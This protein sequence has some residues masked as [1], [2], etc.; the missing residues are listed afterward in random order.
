MSCSTC[1]SRAIL[2][3]SEQTERDISCGKLDAYDWLKDIPDS[4]EGTKLVEVRFKNTRKEF[5]YNEKDLDLK[6]GEYVAVEAERGHDIGQITLTGTV[7]KMQLK[8]KNPK[9]LNK[10]IVYRKATSADL[11]KWQ[12]ARL[13]ERS[14]LIKARQ[15]AEN[16]QLEMKVSDVEFQGDGTKATFYYIAE[17]RIDFRELIKHFAQSF[18]VKIDMRQI[19]SRQEAALIG[20]IGSCGKELCCSTW[21][22]N[23]NTVLT[24]AA[25]I[26]D[27]PHN[28]QKLTGQCGKLKCCLM[29]E[30]GTYLEAQ[31]DF[32][33]VLLELEVEKGIAYPYKKDLLKRIIFYSYEPGNSSHLI[34]VPLE[35][36]KEI[37]Q[38]NKKG[39][40]PELKEEAVQVPEMNFITEENDINRFNKKPN[41]TDAPA[42]KNKRSFH[43]KHQKGNNSDRHQR[44]L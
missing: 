12:M 44:P 35:R 20:G 38:L 5:F 8:R 11:E 34:A 28:A 3:T 22:T 31:E 6:R 13:K 10:K 18:S 1:P 19:G 17:G 29:Y 9:H 36:V 30:L 21:R 2:N 41:R 16:L 40:K 32:P 15:I 23:L 27:L 24:Q 4:P 7:A 33:D 37:I 39:I 14:T 42:N 43:R 26:Q 25:K